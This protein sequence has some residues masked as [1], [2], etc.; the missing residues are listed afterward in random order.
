MIPDR[1]ARRRVSI[2][3]IALACMLLSPGALALSE[4][5]SAR[6]MGRLVERVRPSLLRVTTPPGGTAVLIGVGGELLAPA[7]LVKNDALQVEFAG[8]ARSARLVTRLSELGLAL[9]ALEPN[10]SAEGR[11]PSGPLVRGL[12]PNRPAEGRTPSGPLVRGLEP[13]RSAEG[14][15]TSGPLVRGLEPSQPAEGRTPSGPL[16]R[17]LEPGSYPAAPAGTARALQ[18]GS[19]LVGLYF[20][21]GGSLAVSAGHLGAIRTNPGRPTRLRTDVEGPLGTALFNSRGQ[22][23]ALQAGPPFATVPIDEVRARIA[24]AP[25]PP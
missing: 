9:L 16:V 20:D 18:P 21:R 3:L 22:L 11:T 15:S 10:R 13:N 24:A 4:S 23:V 1:S 6:A 5:I 19:A 8:E 25:G 7:L 2:A 12:E 14:R 17:R